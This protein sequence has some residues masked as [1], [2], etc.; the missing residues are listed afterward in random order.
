MK[1]T[2]GNAIASA[3]WMMV[4]PAIFVLA[5]LALV[6]G[7]VL[8]CVGDIKETRASI[9]ELEADLKQQRTLV[10]VYQ[11]LQKRKEKSLPEGIS[12]NELE[13]LK[14][15]DLAELP[16]VFETLASVSGVELVSATPQVRSLEGGRELLRVDVRMRGEFMTFSPLINRLNHM[17]FVESIESFAIDVTDLGNEIGLSV[18]LAIQ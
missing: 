1:T 14:I 6:F 7:G 17:P 16:D 12:V 18:W 15:E 11:S 5:T 9:V 2:G 8:P 10:P 4:L 13:P 3:R